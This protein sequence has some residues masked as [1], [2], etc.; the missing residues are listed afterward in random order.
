MSCGAG[1][2]GG[3][4]LKPSFNGAGKSSSVSRPAAGYWVYNR[5]FIGS[6]WKCSL[7]SW[8]ETLETFLAQRLDSSPNSDSQPLARPTASLEISI[9]LTELDRTAHRNKME[10]G[11]E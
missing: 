1:G 11:L 7:P 8:V 2:G 4:S 3:G 10:A 5:S 6:V 9:L